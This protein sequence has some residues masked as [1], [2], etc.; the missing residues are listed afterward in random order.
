MAPAIVS[1][2]SDEHPEKARDQPKPNFDSLARRLGPNKPRNVI[3]P[4]QIT[5]TALE[6]NPAIRA[7]TWP[8][9]EYLRL[10]RIDL[11]Q[12]K[13]SAAAL[14]Q[15]VAEGLLPGGRVRPTAACFWSEN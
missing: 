9:L 6:N 15:W 7:A 1:E 5:E 13:V 8:R 3:R 12:V 4:F 14:V 2:Q 10:G 11:S